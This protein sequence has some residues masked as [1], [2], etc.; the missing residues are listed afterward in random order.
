MIIKQ[1]TTEYGLKYDDRLLDTI[2]ATTNFFSNVG[3]VSGPLAAG[4][5][6]DKIGFSNGCNLIGVLSLVFCLVYIFVLWCCQ[7]KF[8]RTVPVDDYVD[9]VVQLNEN[10]NIE[11]RSTNNNNVCD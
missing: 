9:S 5:L 4:F 11:V 2:S 3:E 10:D 7:K 8:T 1:A 6:S